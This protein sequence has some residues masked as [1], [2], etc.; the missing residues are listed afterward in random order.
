MQATCDENGGLTSNHET[1]LPGRHL[2]RTVA[3]LG[4]FPCSSD[5]LHRLRVPEKLVGRSIPI[6]RVFALVS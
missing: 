4:V 6:T 2:V 1:F 5:H 3:A